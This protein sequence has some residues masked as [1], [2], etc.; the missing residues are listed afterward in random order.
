MEMFDL[1]HIQFAFDKEKEYTFDNFL[2]DFYNSSYLTEF[3][4]LLHLQLTIARNKYS[5]L[6]LLFD[7]HH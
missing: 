2:E 5:I 6:L 7:I 4:S 3:A 1:N